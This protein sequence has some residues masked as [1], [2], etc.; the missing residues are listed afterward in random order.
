MAVVSSMVAAGRVSLFSSFISEALLASLQMT[1]YN[2]F[3]KSS[4]FIHLTENWKSRKPTT[5]YTPAQHCVLIIVALVRQCEVKEKT[6][7]RRWA[8]VLFL[9]HMTQ[10]CITTFLP[11]CQLHIYVVKLPFY[12]IRWIQIWWLGT[13][14]HWIHR[15]ANESNLRQLLLCGV[16]GLC[17]SEQMINCGHKGCTWKQRILRGCSIEIMID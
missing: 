14:V 2:Y 5:N 6:F 9:P 13:V 11:I 10:L 3:G 16:A 7:S 8:E 4:S 1:S 15:H 12:H 17:C